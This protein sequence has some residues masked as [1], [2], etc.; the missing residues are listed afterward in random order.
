MGHSFSLAKQATYCAEDNSDLFRDLNMKIAH[1]ACHIHKL[2][3]AICRSSLLYSETWVAAGIVNEIHFGS[4]IELESLVLCL[5][6]PLVKKADTAVLLR[7]CRDLQMSR[8]VKN[9]VNEKAEFTQ[10]YP[11]IA[12]ESSRL[13][14][15]KKNNL[16]AIVFLAR[17]HCTSSFLGT[18]MELIDRNLQHVIC[19]CL[20]IVEN[21][22]IT[23]PL[24]GRKKKTTVDTNRAGEEEATG[25]VAGPVQK[26]TA[27]CSA[28]RVSLQ[29]CDKSTFVPSAS[30]AIVSKA[31]EGTSCTPRTRLISK[32]AQMKRPAL[33]GE[34]AEKAEEVTK[35]SPAKKKRRVPLET[36][37][38]LDGLLQPS[39]MQPA[40]ELAYLAKLS[41]HCE[42]VL[43]L[44]QQREE[45]I[46]ASEARKTPRLPEGVDHTRYP[47]P[48]PIDDGD[49]APSS[50]SAVITRASRSSNSLD[51][52]ADAES[53]VEMEFESAVV[54]DKQG[55]I[56]QIARPPVT[57]SGQFNAASDDEER[58][59]C[60]DLYHQIRELNSSVTGGIGHDSSHQ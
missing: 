14:A 11:K 57:D 10:K 1:P 41:A 19:K 40:E 20:D 59:E 13:L 35:A 23:T 12:A 54:V 43:K 24:K 26:D 17:F 33:V 31:D 42:K 27:A 3:R 47:A 7:L 6:I 36:I 28:R 56:A 48:V 55:I 9:L 8:M 34:S 18:C 32:K 30:L 49:S 39:K 37:P 38:A 4:D 16:K 22:A 45:D 52:F 2:K 50:P 46:R 51:R 25:E 44:I 60:F 15:A 58:L 53:G 21:F 5:N 29:E